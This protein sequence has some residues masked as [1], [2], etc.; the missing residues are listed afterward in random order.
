M[1][2]AGERQSE[3]FLL[4]PYERLGVPGFSQPQPGSSPRIWLSPAE[5]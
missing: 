4:Y 5:R 2:S 3:S 1:T